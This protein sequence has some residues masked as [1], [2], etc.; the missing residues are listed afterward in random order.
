MQDSAEEVGWSAT[1][2][3]MKQICDCNAFFSSG[4]AIV[5]ASAAW[6][7]GFPSQPSNRK[8]ERELENVILLKLAVLLLL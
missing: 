8:K 1:K 4:K 5:Y 3:F 7:V 2:V 6:A